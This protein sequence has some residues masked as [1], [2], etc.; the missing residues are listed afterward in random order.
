VLAADALSG[1]STAS[2]LFVDHSM[3]P[4]LALTHAEDEIA[5]GESIV[6]PR[7]D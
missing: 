4:E 5:E 2:G 7:R 1:T 6:D 3:L